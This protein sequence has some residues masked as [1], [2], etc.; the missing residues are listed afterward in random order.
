MKRSFMLCRLCQ[1]DS[2]VANVSLLTGTCFC[3]HGWLYSGKGTEREK[4]LFTIYH[5][6]VQ[7]TLVSMQ[8]LD[9]SHTIEP[10]MPVY[11]GSPAPEFT[12]LTSIGENG[13][14][15]QLF[16]LSSH[17]GTHVDLPS[18]MI[19]GACSLD[20]FGPDRFYGNG[21]VIDVSVSNGGIITLDDFVRCEPA[22]RSSEYLLLSS[23]WCRYWGKPSYYEGYPVLTAEAARWL[24][25]FGLN[26][27]GV[28]MISVDAPG[29]E[30]YP[31][32]KLLLERGIVIVENLRDLSFL[33][34]RQFIFSCFPLKISGAEAA[35][36]RA[37]ALL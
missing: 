4:Q 30:D 33:L 8:L 21:F 5:V 26:G 19:E 14:A 11:P 36:V 29:D 22:I 1:N 34:S 35:P 25:G 6:S 12:A 32:H 10:A 18:H 9:L 15:E 37:V 24:C 27:I 3:L 28:D 23:G 20:A 16:T 17:T 2:F 13:F 31:V 7:Q